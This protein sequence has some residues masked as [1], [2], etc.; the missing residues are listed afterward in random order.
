ML[1]SPSIHFCVFDHLARTPS[2][3]TWLKGC[4]FPASVDPELHEATGQKEGVDHG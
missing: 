1:S 4:A 3:Q 2:K